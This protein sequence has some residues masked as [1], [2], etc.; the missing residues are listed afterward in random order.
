LL[1]LRDGN[2]IYPYH[3]ATVGGA[4]EEGET[5]EAAIQRE[6]DEE[7]RYKLIAPPTFWCIRDSGSSFW[8]PYAATKR[9][10]HFRVLPRG[11]FNA[12][13]G[14]VASEPVRASG[15]PR[16]PSTPLRRGRMARRLVGSRTR[17]TTDT[18]ARNTGRRPAP[19]PRARRRQAW[20]RQRRSQRASEAS[21]RSLFQYAGPTRQRRAGWKSSIGLPDGSSSRICEPPGPV[22]MSFRNG[23]PAARSRSTSL[24]RS[25]TT[26]W[27]LFQPPGAGLR[28][29]GMG[30]PAE[31]VGP[32]RRSRRSP[33][34]TSANAGDAFDSNVNPR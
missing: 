3:W 4:V 13:R 21:C 16:Q 29:S 14:A 17:R 6:V 34:V 5:L 10:R 30:R 24:A 9:A 20:R 25:S 15:V 8:M 26:K 7:T 31:L 32:L 33:R 12:N 1:Q 18:P 2:G 28:P 11:I 27:I 19:V 23:T 22:T